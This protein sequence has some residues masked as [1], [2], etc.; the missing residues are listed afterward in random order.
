MKGIVLAG[1]TG[2]RLRPATLAL[3]KQLL[4]IFDKPL[5][6]F[7]ISTLMAAGIREILIISTPQHLEMFKKLLGDGSQ[8]GVSFSYLAQ[9]EPK[10]IAESFIIGEKFINND[11]CGLVLGD[12]IFHGSGIGTSLKENIS[13]EGAD[14][15]AF[16]V[17]NPTEYGVIE[18]DSNDCPISIEE[19]PLKPKSNLAVTGLYFFDNTVS[20]R[21]KLV[22]P[23]MRGELEITSLINSYLLEKK[24]NVHRIS[25]GAAWFDTGTF[26]SMHDAA[27]YVRIIQE[28]TNLQI[29]CLEELSLRQAWINTD[30]AR[31]VAK[32]NGTEAL[33]YINGI[34]EDLGLA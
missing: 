1:G 12:N 23:S 22:K 16:Y 29:A 2:S 7:P 28:R 11:S 25:R 10:G 26:K 13:K 3:S 4:T 33:N 31:H 18:L 24:L 27:T 15:Y 17:N 21:A 20:E 19:K 30:S 6:Y 34:I 8:F 32:L 9:A 14:I 5:V